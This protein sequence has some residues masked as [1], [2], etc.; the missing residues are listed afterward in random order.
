LSLKTKRRRKK[1]RKEKK[2]K[3]R[4][5]KKRKRLTSLYYLISNLKK[6]KVFFQNCVFNLIPLYNLL[7]NFIFVLYVPVVCLYV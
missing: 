3:E 1:K 6:K 7:F 4:K 2:R 5:E